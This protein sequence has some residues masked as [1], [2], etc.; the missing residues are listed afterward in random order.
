MS[1]DL[2]KQTM[3]AFAL[4]SGLGALA[5]AAA[6]A[7]DPAAVRSIEIAP[8]QRI[9]TD[10]QFPMA[11]LREK[12]VVLTFDD[13]PNPETTPLILSALSK[14]CVRATFF[15]IGANAKAHPELL[16][17]ELHDGHTL[18]NHT[19]DHENLADKPLADAV[20]DIVKGFGPIQAAGAPAAFL[21]FPNLATTP[22]LLDWTRQHGVAVVS[23]DVDASDWQGDP[24]AETMKRLLDQLTQKGRGVILLHDSQPNTAKM[25]PELLA[26]L[27]QRGYTFAQLKPAPHAGLSGE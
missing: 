14:A 23:V 5:P 12:E 15:V 21:R 25:V 1:G 11:P 16:K 9:G 6:A 13:G 2:L 27:K 7:C 8:G 18:G 3:R 20:K 17:R 10:S 24:P 4:V 26:T 19:F 22:A